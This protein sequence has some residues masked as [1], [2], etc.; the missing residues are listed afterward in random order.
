MTLSALGWLGANSFVV[1]AIITVAAYQGFEK[2]LDVLIASS[3]GVE[4]KDPRMKAA[5]KDRKKLAGW[6]SA[7]GILCGAG[8]VVC[9]GIAFYVA[10]GDT[11]SK[12]FPTEYWSVV[13]GIYATAVLYL[14]AQLGLYI[15]GRWQE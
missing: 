6:L 7:A 11:D 5:W 12:A 14:L 1:R 10:D 13:V 8:T 2:I 3:R 4:P 15:L 9:Y